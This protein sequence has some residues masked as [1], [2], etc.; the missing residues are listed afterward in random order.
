MN[1][2]IE[3]KVRL[4]EWLIPQ[5]DARDVIAS[6]L[7][8]GDGKN[9]ADL[10]VVSTNGIRAIE[11]KGPRDSLYTLAAQTAAYLD[12]FNEVTIAISR[13]HL[14]IARSAIPRQA[15][16]LLLDPE[17]SWLRKPRHRKHLSKF[18]AQGWLTTKDLSAKLGFSHRMK[19]LT[20]MRQ[21]ADDSMSS[22][23]LSELAYQSVLLRTQPRFSRFKAELG[24]RITLDDVQ[25][26]T[27][28]SSVR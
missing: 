9:R 19:G 28:P 3:E 2:A 21:I 11:I 6:E 5:L 15:G 7:P 17:I 26:L 22:A 12:A 10:A 24:S 8:F 13:K 14:P 1:Y 23:A 27:L 4:L 18:G 25:M 20:H 16:I